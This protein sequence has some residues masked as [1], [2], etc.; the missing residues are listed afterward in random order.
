MA[1][2]S[3]AEMAQLVSTFRDNDANGFV[4]SLVQA[5]DSKFKDIR[6]E[7]AATIKPGQ[8]VTGIVRTLNTDFI[9]S[10]TR[11]AQVSYTIECYVPVT[12]LAGNAAADVFL[13]V[14]GTPVSNP[15]EELDVTLSLGL[16]LR[17]KH[18]KTFSAYVPAGAIVNLT[19][20]IV[21]AG[22]ATYLYGQETL[23]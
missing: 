13:N 1:L 22:T 4:Q 17:P 5:L 14:N 20:V 11:N 16:S 9:V 18:R 12:L 8:G 2:F 21:G 6:V 19:S 3:Q 15:G 23:Q 7:V 10:D